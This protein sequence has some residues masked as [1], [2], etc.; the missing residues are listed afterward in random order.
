MNF[1][2]ATD[3]GSASAMSSTT[4]HVVRR[5]RAGE[6]SVEDDTLTQNTEKARA[7]ELRIVIDADETSLSIGDTLQVTGHFTS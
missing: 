3:R 5:L 7:M 6:W 2:P 4:S 1:T